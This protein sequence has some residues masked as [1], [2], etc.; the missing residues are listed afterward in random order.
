[1]IIANFQQ[2]G[3]VYQSVRFIKHDTSVA[4]LVSKFI[5][6]KHIFAL[7]VGRT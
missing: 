6:L 1:M 3:T 2:D 4:S 5:L 7:K